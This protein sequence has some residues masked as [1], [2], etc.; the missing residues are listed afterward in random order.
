MCGVSHNG[1]ISKKRK[2]K[3]KKTSSWDSCTLFCPTPQPAFFCPTGGV[4]L[5]FRKA[6]GCAACSPDRSWAVGLP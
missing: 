4:L 5:A 3:K 6:I 1:K 2:T